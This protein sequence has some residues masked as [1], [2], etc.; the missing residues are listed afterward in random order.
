MSILDDLDQRTAPRGAP[1][2]AT[3]L[4]NLDA[5]TAPNASR[6]PAS[7]VRSA[8]S[9][10]FM[11]GSTSGVLDQLD[12]ATRRVEVQPGQWRQV[13]SQQ[14]ATASLL[15]TLDD[16]TKPIRDIR[17]AGI[18]D[19]LTGTSGPIDYGVKNPPP[20]LP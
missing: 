3:Y 12:D 17:P 16:Q 10:K 2:A 15:D 18:L 13:G 19:R 1:P 9:E 8:P 7:A 5:Q 20:P 6:A 14:P 4:D 11:E